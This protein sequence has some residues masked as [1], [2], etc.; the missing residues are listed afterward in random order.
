MIDE[1]LRE[2]AR[3]DNRWE[4]ESIRLTAFPDRS[5][6]LQLDNI[7]WWRSVTGTPP[8]TRISRLRLPGFQEEGPFAGGKLVLAATPARIDWHLVPADVVEPTPGFQFLGVLS[9]CLGDFVAGMQAWLRTAPQLERLAFGA[10]AML[11]VADRADG[12]QKL[13]TL[14][15]SLRID[16][17]NSSDLSYQI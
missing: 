7:E 17:E 13:S 2:L 9:D 4:A 1:Q 11:H 6:N 8:E 16:A 15:H 14:L 5:V 12:Y 10:T 3:H